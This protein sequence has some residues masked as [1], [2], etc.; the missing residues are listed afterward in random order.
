MLK[1]SFLGLALGTLL[2]LTSCAVY[3]TPGAG[4][5]SGRVRFGIEVSDV[6]RVFEATRGAGATYY[7]G[8]NVSFR[9]LTTRDGYI[10]LTA[11]DPDGRVYTFARNIYVPGGQTITISGP[12]AGNV[13]SLV[14]PRGLQRVRASFTPSPTSGR[15]TFQGRAGEGQWTQSIVTEVSDYDVRD[16]AETQ[17]YLQ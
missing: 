6:I 11:L 1:K 7:V 3:V 2:V 14:P 8:E 15:I 13:F 10:T 9:V 16:I 12:D 17:F 4:G 5:A